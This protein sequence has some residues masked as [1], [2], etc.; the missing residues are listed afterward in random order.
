MKV[1][2]LLFTLSLSILSVSLMAQMESDSTGLLGDHFSL[3]GT[4]DVF[5][6][7]E[8]LEDFE[9]AINNQHKNINN[10]DLNED[11]ETDYIRVEDNHEGDVHA[12]VLQAV[13]SKDEVQ[14]VAV[15]EIEKDGDES[16]TLQIV[17][18]ESLYG[19]EHFVEP[20]DEV[21][22]S[23][24]KGG[25]NADYRMTRIVVNVW[26]WPS[27]RFIYGPRYRVYRSPYYWG[28]YPRV[29][30]P[31]RPLTWRSYHVNRVHY[32]HRYRV[33]NTHRVVRAHKV[34]T[35]RRKA[36]KTVTVRS[37][38]VTRVNRTSGKTTVK[39]TNTKTV[40]KRD[41]NGNVKVG[42][43]SKTTGVSKD[44]SG[45]VK[46]GQKT[47]KTGVSKNANGTVKA[48]TTTKKRGA[49]KDAKGIVTKGKAKKTVK[50]KNGKTTKKKKTVKKKRKG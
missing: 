34:Y 47:T 22:E 2:N 18:D 12:I 27:V 17:G 24:G 29:W 50:S 45:N 41:A 35:P 48:G 19:T 1:S 46:A 39:K 43:K 13:L 9:S 36:S 33:V 15:I 10:L 7:S 20:F 4:L 23:G 37:K 5:K 38:T 40:A 14:D 21:A 31:W 44:A 25:P 11:G 42:Q 28:F 49:K 32:T 16:A 30:R 26:F 8:S 3:E 6:S